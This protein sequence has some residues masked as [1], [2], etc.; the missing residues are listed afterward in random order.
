[1]GTAGLLERERELGALDNALERARQGRGVVLTIEGE[2]G[3]GKSRL[4]AAARERARAAGFTVLGARA[5]ELER[6]L[7]FG[8]SGQL[9]GHTA[10]EPAPSRMGDPERALSEIRRLHDAL[11][12]LAW[13]S[14]GASVPLL[15]AVDDLQWADEPSLRF[16]AHLTLR[17]GDLPVLLVATIRGGEAG[18]P[19]AL[20]EP[21][22]QGTVLRPEPLSVDAVARLAR[23]ELGAALGDATCRACA[24]ASGGNPFYVCELLRA[25]RDDGAPP[26]PERVRGI[27][28]EAVLRSLMVRLGRLGA[29]SSA[30]ARAVAVLGDGAALGESAALAGLDGR[31]AGRAADAL[32]GVGLFAPGEPL[33]LAHP[34]IGATLRSDMGAFERAREHRRAATLLRALDAPPERVATHLLHVARQGDEWV[35]ATLRAAACV[36]AERGDPPAAARLLGRALEE[37]PAAAERTELLLRLA[38]MEALAGGRGARTHFEEALGGVTD[39]AR[40][41]SVLAA[42]AT[43]AHHAGDCAEAV[44]LARRGRAELEPA[45][46]LEGRLVALELG[47]ALLDPDLQPQAAAAMGSMLEES[48]SGCPPGE[49][50]LAA[51]VAGQL[52]RSDPPAAVRTIAERVTAAD[53]LIDPHDASS[54]IGWVGYALVWVDELEWAESWL[55]DALE[56]AARR[57]AVSAD[58]VAAALRALVRH[59]RGSLGEAVADGERALEA[60][61]HGWVD[62]PASVPALVRT[63]IARGDLDAAAEALA[64]ADGADPERPE[65]ALFLEAS[66]RLR[67]CRG[68]AEGALADALAAGR[69][70]EER[71]GIV[72]PRA[73]AWRRLAALASHH[74]GREREAHDLLEPLLSDLRRIG[75]GRQLG[76]TLTAAGV[77]SGGRD[78]LALHAEAVAALEASP[79]K[80]H[81][82]H[83]VIE[84]GA[85]LRRAGQRRAARERLYAGLEQADRLDAVRLVAQARGELASLGLRPRRAARSGPDS[86]TPSERRIAELAARDLSNP[87]IGH[88]LHVTR[89]TVET[90]LRHIYRKLGVARRHEL[91]AALDVEAS[92]SAEFRTADA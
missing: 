72:L 67:L 1:M 38:E 33:S 59:H 52:A 9:L 35:V 56:A 49:P 25:L 66:A 18:E 63:H 87:Q 48:R 71:Y 21:L 50:A 91:A 41:A 30:L 51:A 36:A 37:P 28:P 8:V 84:H 55:D 74:L 14:A 81:R 58:A 77:I 53:P 65:R 29:E 27:A 76:A 23:H 79:A 43:L 90:H 22:R 85:A 5:S 17:L 80:L 73:F 7:P 57:G 3:A 6:S 89:K 19:L 26:S 46:P 24:E 20:L 10:P 15:V 12:G 70:I 60:Y 83:A 68:D 64:F 42:L 92:L 88:E 45:H 61:R 69:H 62:S 78:G 54:A 47:A 31:A 82:A 40:R 75:P 16:L 11:L 34:L 4:L 32:A 86:L 2:A 44:E 39:G 13:P